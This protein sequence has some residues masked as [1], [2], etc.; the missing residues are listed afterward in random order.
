MDTD[1]TQGASS[2]TEQAEAPKLTTYTVKCSISVV[3]TLSEDELRSE[4]EAA[5]YG[6]LTARNEETISSVQIHLVDVE[7]IS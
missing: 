2:S 5:L 3:T 7:A 4:L 1:T 6:D